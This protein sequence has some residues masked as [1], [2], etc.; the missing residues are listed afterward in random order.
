MPVRK[1]FHRLLRSCFG[2]D[3]RP[4]PSTFLR[5]LRASSCIA[6]GPVV[7]TEAF[8]P[9][10]K[11]QNEREAAGF[12]PKGADISINWE[13]TPDALMQ[14]RRNKNNSGHGVA[15]VLL[16]DLEAVRKTSMFATGLYWERRQIP[17]NPYHG[18]I[19]YGVELPK[20]AVK[21]GAAF[22]AASAKIVSE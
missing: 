17:D 4:L 15:R 1:F 13:D 9:S 22:L 10:K 5:G 2:E 14:I 19:I 16:S 8:T 7:A 6:P 11:A 20:H 12:E 3:S 21:A 18:N